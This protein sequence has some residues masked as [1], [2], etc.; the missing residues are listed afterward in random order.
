M[1]PKLQK[2]KTIKQALDY[3][4][5]QPANKK[6]ELDTECWELLAR[7]L[8]IHANSGNPE[9]IGSMGRANRAQRIILNRTTGRRRA[10][11]H[12]F[13]R[14]QQ[15]VTFHDMTEGAEIE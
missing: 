3:V 6:P 7:A 5:A 9:V 13:Q 2:H 12:P 10:G 1:P 4:K 15:Q 11:T 14:N 8:Y